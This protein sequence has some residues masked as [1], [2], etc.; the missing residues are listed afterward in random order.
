M[1]SLGRKF[2]AVRPAGERDVS[3]PTSSAYLLATVILFESSQSSPPLFTVV[4]H[5]KYGAS[6][7]SLLRNRCREED[8][9][10]RR[11]RWGDV[12]RGGV[13]DMLTSILSI[14]MRRREAG[15]VKTVRLIWFTL[16]HVY[17]HGR[18]SYIDMWWV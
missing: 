8:V 5:F 11:R 15:V 4:F 13:F 2:S 9:R 12:R 17:V 7:L 3:F 16:C 14:Q 10:R 6:A 1:K 18:F